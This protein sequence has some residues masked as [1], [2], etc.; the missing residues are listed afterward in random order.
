MR[1]IKWW[2]GTGVAA[3]LWF[4]AEEERGL[5]TENEKI[6]IIGALGGWVFTGR[7]K[8]DVS[9]VSHSL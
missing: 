5:G 9:N 6:M 4:G 7:R 8:K 2:N 1:R 3:F